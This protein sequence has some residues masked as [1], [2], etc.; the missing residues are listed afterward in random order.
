MVRDRGRERDGILQSMAKPEV[1][2]ARCF[3]SE[4]SGLRGDD[5]L[6]NKAQ[7]NGL[8]AEPLE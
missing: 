7:P 8:S 3:Q 2:G 5:R 4:P 1:T 6:G